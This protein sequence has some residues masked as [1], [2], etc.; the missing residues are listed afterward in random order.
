MAKPT[1]LTENGGSKTRLLADSTATTPLARADA[2]VESAPSGEATYPVGWPGVATHRQ[3]DA[4]TTP[5]GFTTIGAGPVVLAAALDGTTVRA[6]TCDS[7]GRQSIGAVI[8]GTAATNLGKAIDSGAGATDTGVAVLAVRDDALSTLTPAETDYVPLRTDS[9]GALWVNTGG[10]GGTS[11]ADETAFTAGSTQ[12]NPIGGV[13]STDAVTGAGDRIGAVGMTLQ[14]EMRVQLGSAGTAVALTGSRLQVESTLA[15]AQTLATVTSVGTVTTVTTVSAVSTVNAVVPGTGATNLGKAE[16]AVHA[17]GDTGIAA[18]GVAN[19]G[20]TVFCATGDYCPR[21]T[22][23]EGSSRTIGN[24]AHDAIDSGNPL[25]IGGKAVNMSALPADVG[26][27]DRVDASFD[28][29]GRQLVIVDLA[30]PTKDQG[31]DHGV[32]VPQRGI[33]VGVTAT[34]DQTLLAAD[35]SNIY[36]VLDVS[37]DIF[38]GT[39]AP[40]AKAYVS[41]F[42]GPSASGVEF[43]RI[44]APTAANGVTTK[45][46]PFRIPD[47]GASNQAVVA[48]L[49]ASLGTNGEYS[50]TVHAYKTTT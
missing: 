13:V 34:T 2:A 7:S 42:H 44:Y 31:W 5:G 12:A 49:N 50:V 9:T 18:W 28:L 30:V 45:A 27:L 20:N 11:Y 36:N 19:D 47:R 17:T 6:T 14:R 48:K 46:Q 29:K 1:A 16:D 43:M 24:R 26:V 32:V 10:G 3:G 33:A 25:K 40:A 41:L 15:A 35:A 23:T 4:L 38:A 8:P 21:A 39:A 37:V 22:D